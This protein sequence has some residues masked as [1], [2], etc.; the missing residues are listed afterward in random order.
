M[1]DTDDTQRDGE[2]IDTGEPI[3]LL[4]DLEEPVSDSFMGALHRRIQRRLLVTDIGRLS[5]TGVGIVIIE[6]FNLVFGFFG[7]RDTNEGKE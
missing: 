5:W 2:T 4:R 1:A 7:A 3:V 6:F